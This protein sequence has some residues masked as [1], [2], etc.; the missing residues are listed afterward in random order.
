MKTLTARTPG[1][2]GAE[3][4]HPGCAEH[5]PGRWW[6][7]RRNRAGRRT[8]GRRPAGPGPYALMPWLLLGLGA[9]SNLWKGETPNPVVGAVGVLLFNSLYIHLVFRSF[10]PARRGTTGSYVLLGALA[11]ITFGLAAGYGGSW[12]LF[13]PLLSLASGTVL[14]GRPLACALVGLSACGVAVAVWRG[15]RVS[16]PWTIGYGTFLSGAVT[17]A[18][19]AL[20]ET[21]RELRDAQAELARNAVERERLRFSRDL[22][23]LLGH[24][25]SVI[26]VKSEAA[27]RLAPRDL[28]AALGQISDIESVG[29]QA[30]TEVRE[31]VTGYREGSLTG[32]LDGAVSALAAAGIEGTVHRA[33][34]PLAPRSEAL[35][36]WVVREAV[37]NVVRHSGAT[38]CVF[39]VT[40]GSERVVLTVTDDGSLA[41]P[42]GGAVPGPRRGPGA[43]GGEPSYSYGGT[44]LV[45]LS[46]RLALAGGSL[47]AGPGPDGGFVVRAELP[48]EPGR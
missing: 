41:E 5:P 12:L 7:P 28:D 40:S 1:A 32:E 34:P 29:R 21:V 46:E 4:P 20:S 48:G 43:D 22:H 27:R 9:F 13:F 24:T 25:L 10:V 15:D 26:V 6:P 16:D 11:A 18:I 23:D 42:G 38:H 35:L 19:L 31:A 2:D 47:R 45:G 39:S 17:A 14:R 37:T 30:L 33:G 8:A 36:G 44:G 3:Q